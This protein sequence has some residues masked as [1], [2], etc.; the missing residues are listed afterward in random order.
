MS[1][2]MGRPTD[3]PK[4]EVLR[5]RLDKNTLEKLDLISKEE[6]SNR[7]EVVRILIEK[8]YDEIKK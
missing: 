3:S 5:V 4:N 1:I 7:S 2:K 8:K 6:K